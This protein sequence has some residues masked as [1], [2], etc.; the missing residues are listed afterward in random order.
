MRYII[1]ADGKGIRWNNYNNIPKHL[2]SFDGETI[3]SRTVR[4]IRDRDSQ[5]EIFITSHDPRYDIPGA[6]RHEP[7]NNVLEIDRFT[8]ELIQDDIC[9]LYGD[10]FYSDE[11]MDVI[12]G[13]DTDKVLFFGNG[14]SI[15]A[16][17][18][19]DGKLFDAHV[20]RVRKLFLENA[21]DTC[22]G[23]QVYQSYA[24]LA[25]GDRSQTDC[26]IYINDETRDF[27]APEDLQK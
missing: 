18:A 23:W 9:F 6:V 15:V 7:L 26:F 14:R 12:L 3:L 21:I 22:K 20:E 8:K 25:F 2:I 1:M 4:L 16:I 10:T 17:K 13:T 19:A 27:N 11:A 24:G 5:A